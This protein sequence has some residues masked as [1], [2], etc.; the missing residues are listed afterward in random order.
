DRLLAYQSTGA[1]MLSDVKI[2]IR[3]GFNNGESD[4]HKVINLFPI[5][6]VASRNLGAALNKMARNG[7]CR[8]SIIII[9][10]PAE[11]ADHGRQRQSR[12]SNALRDNDTGAQLQ[13][14]YYGPRSKVNIGTQ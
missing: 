9:K 14:S 6:K 12:I 3:F 7:S 11:F 10:G 13:C 4:I 2:T 8:H 1:F 5:G